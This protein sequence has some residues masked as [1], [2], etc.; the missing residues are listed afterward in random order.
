MFKFYEFFAGG[1]MA[2]AG[3]GSSWQCLFSNDFDDKKASCYINH[4]GKES[5]KVGDV[6]KL[7]TQDLPDAADLIWASFPCQ[8][9]SLAGAGAGLKGERS[10][11]FW[12]FWNL[13][14]QLGEEK[15]APKIVALE[16]V[17]GA[18]TSHGGKDFSAIC[19]AL[20]DADYK[21]GAMVIDAV[22]FLPQSRPRL[23][24]VGVHSSL[25]APADIISNSHLKKWHTP[26]L[27]EAYQGLSNST[28]QTWLWWKLPQV[29]ARNSVL[30]DLI[31]DKPEGV[32]WHTPEETERLL[33][34]MSPVNRAKVDAASK[35]GRRVVGS[36]YR[37]TRLDENGNR[38]QRAEIRFDDVAGCL[39]TPAGGSS[40]QVIM[41]VKGKSIR[42]RLLSPREAARLMGLPEEYEL[43]TNYNEAYH[44]AGDGVAV[45][46]V[47]FLS[48]SILEPLLRETEGQ[49]RKAA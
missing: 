21:F 35:A 34:M 47:R 31:E 48:E 10:G 45:P 24:I 15:R 2:R 9:L 17:C 3:L 6:A 36:I 12:P 11:T 27:L 49:K 46:V 23:F 18:L 16:N 29:P 41:L 8:D 39:R 7:T 25:Q 33:G 1:G 37:R 43:P 28:K 14:K 32:R 30:A 13:I 26:K 44:L 19:D 42:S 38:V 22:D 20:A 5:L 4:W 40:R